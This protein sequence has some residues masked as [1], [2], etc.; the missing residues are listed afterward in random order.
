MFQE[1][2]MADRTYPQCRQG[3]LQDA[4]VVVWEGGA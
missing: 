1:Y 4:L 2:D 3:S